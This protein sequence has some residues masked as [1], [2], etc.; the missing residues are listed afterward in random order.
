MPWPR[1]VLFDLDDTLV[2]DDGVTDVCWTLACERYWRQ[3]PAK[4]AAE[5]REAVRRQAD[6]FYSSPDRPARPV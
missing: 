5:L 1:A 4:S 2:S 6:W 3:T